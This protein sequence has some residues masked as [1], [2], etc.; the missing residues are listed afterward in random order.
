VRHQADTAS[1]M[2]EGDAETRNV[3]IDVLQVAQQ[4]QEGLNH[5]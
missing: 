1:D 3:L 4:D 2:I 5:K